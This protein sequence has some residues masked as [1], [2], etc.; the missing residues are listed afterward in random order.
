[1][2]KD[3]VKEGYKNIVLIAPGFASD[4][5]ETLEELNV[6]ERESFLANGGDNYSV[7]PCLNDT[8][9]HILFLK[10]LVNKVW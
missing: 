6:T 5:L 3:G 7:V 4:C 10:Q 9:E 1:V 8:K 2:L